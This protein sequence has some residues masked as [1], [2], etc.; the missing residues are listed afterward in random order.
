MAIGRQREGWTSAGPLTPILPGYLTVRGNPI[1]WCDVA[2]TSSR[3]H[4]VGRA[5]RGCQAVF[6]PRPETERSAVAGIART[7]LVA[8]WVGFV[9]FLRVLFRALGDDLR[10]G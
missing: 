9:E 3:R 6:V 10:R 5:E 7:L 4:R 1:L 2:E 8:T